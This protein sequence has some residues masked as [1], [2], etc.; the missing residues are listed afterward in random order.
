MGPGGIATIIA[1]ASLA[2]IALAVAYAIVRVGR[3]VDEASASLKV[4]TEETTPL[5]H[6]VTNTVELVNAPL[7]TIASVSKN[8]GDVSSKIA[9]ATE[10]FV[11]KNGLAMKVAASLLGV[12][13]EKKSRKQASEEKPRRRRT[14]TT[15]EDAE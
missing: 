13:Q 9:N 12:A 11:D 5:L 7:T 8:I 14:K 4:L 2:V 15:N 3:L 10:S 6:E 1:A